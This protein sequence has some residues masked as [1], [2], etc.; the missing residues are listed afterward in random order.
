[1]LADRLRVRACPQLFDRPWGRRSV[2][3][4][5]DLASK[6]HAQTNPATGNADWGRY[7]AVTL[8][9]DLNFKFH[10][11]AIAKRKCADGVRCVR[12]GRDNEIGRFREAGQRDV[13]GRRFVRL[14]PIGMRVVDAEEFEPPPAEFSRQ[15]RDFPGCDLVIPDGIR[16]DVA[17]GERLRDQSVLPRQN[18]AA[19]PI[20]LAAGMLQEL[21]VYFATTSDDPLHSG[22]IL[23]CGRANR[24]AGAQ[25]LP[26]AAPN[27]R[28]GDCPYVKETKIEHRKTKTGRPFVIQG[29]RPALFLRED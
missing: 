11:P 17:R 13:R 27:S 23:R 20:R 2:P 21:A 24:A 26:D 18:S 22:S 12:P 28:C 6:F 25:R 1:M 7:C 14:H 15:T 9:Q 5:E 8:G 4:T 16:R 10:R 29:E 3:S 19:F